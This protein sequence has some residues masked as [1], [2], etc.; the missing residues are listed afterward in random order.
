MQQ[1]GS[2]PASKLASNSVNITVGAVV[3]GLLTFAAFTPTAFRD[4]TATPE[5]PGEAVMLLGPDTPAD[6]AWR[7]GTGGTLVLNG[8]GS[9]VSTGVC[10]R[11]TE[12]HDNGL[13]VTSVVPRRSGSGTWTLGS[14]D[15]PGTQVHLSH[16][17][18]F[19]ATAE[20]DVRKID[21]VLHLWT[22]TVQNLGTDAEVEIDSCLLT[23]KP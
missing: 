14:S 17:G 22:T 6:T 21:G 9:F 23:E 2:R 3:A 20:F 12:H 7:D 18:A 8:D 1:S 16:T 19:R 13:L 5:A 11:F 15:A 10:G 4:D